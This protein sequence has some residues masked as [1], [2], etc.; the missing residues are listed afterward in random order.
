[1]HS[2]LWTGRILSRALWNSVTS[3]SGNCTDPKSRQQQEPFILSAVSGFAKDL[4]H[5]GIK[6]GQFGD[7]AWF[8][9][10]CKSGDAFGKFHDNYSDK[11]YLNLVTCN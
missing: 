9:S 11:A 10:K 1:M 4:K 6:K 2:I 8:V 5:T 7:D 3:R